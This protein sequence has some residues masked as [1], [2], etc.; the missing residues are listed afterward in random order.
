VKIAIYSVLSL[1][2]GAGGESWIENV[3]LRLHQRGHSILV[4]TT[5]HGNVRNPGIKQK[6]IDKGITVMEVD[7]YESVFKLPKVHHIWNLIHVLKDYEILYFNNAFA[8][9]E[10]LVYFLKVICK[11]PVL[12]G[13]HG[14]FPET[15]GLLRR[16]YQV[17]INRTFSGLFD[18]HHVLN[19]ERLDLLLM[20][21]YHNV[22]FLP[23]GVDM[24]TFHPCE[25]DIVFTVMFAG[26]MIA[27]KGIDKFAS[28]VE[29]INGS[30]ASRHTIRFIIFGS[31]P[32]ADIPRT[33]QRKFSNVTYYGYESKEFLQKAYAR[34]HVFVSPSRFDEFPLSPLEAQASGTPV[35]A[36]SLPAT[37]EIII[38]GKTGFLIEDAAIKK[39]VERILFLSELWYEETMR[40]QEYSINSRSS[41]KKYDWDVV[42]NRL[43]VVF[44]DL[45]T[46][47]KKS[48]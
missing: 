39:I 38:E 42:V 6:L 37:R 40:Y 36:T 20:R 12:A 11:I 34:S 17:T 13:Y 3:A 7:N 44:E 33:L 18:G 21:N 24:T 29:T 4:L 48:R 10:V 26:S 2:N 47:T 41:A 45:T 23:N 35:I 31:G 1:S 22:A 28:V 27:Q 25:K 46:V 43:L 15:G 32:M 30:L 5:K 16:L 19:K 14:L 8:L 9:N